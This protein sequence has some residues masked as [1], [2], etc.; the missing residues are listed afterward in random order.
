[1]HALTLLQLIVVNNTSV[2]LLAAV[3]MGCRTTM[4]KPNYINL[5][6][7]E[8][9]VTVGMQSHILSLGSFQGL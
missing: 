7:D 9:L 2:I 1:M 5:K 8:A 3:F 4:I 6:Q